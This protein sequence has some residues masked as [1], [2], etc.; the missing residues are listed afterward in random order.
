M[1]LFQRR[2]Q[3]NA[4]DCRRIGLTV[5]TGYQSAKCESA[6]YGQ[7]L[8]KNN[9]LQ[10]CAAVEGGLGIIAAS[11]RSIQNDQLHGGLSLRRS[12]EG[13]SLQFG[14]AVERLISDGLHRARNDNLLKRLAQEEHGIGDFVETFRQSDLR[15]HG[16]AAERLVTNGKRIALF[17]CTE[18]DLGYHLVVEECVCGNVR[19]RV[20]N[21]H[22]GASRFSL[23]AEEQRG[24]NVLRCFLPFCVKHLVSVCVKNRLI[25]SLIQDVVNG[26]K[27]GAVACNRNL[28][29][30]RA[31]R[32]HRKL[33]LLVQI[34]RLERLRKRNLGQHGAGCKRAGTDVGHAFRNGQAGKLAAG[35]E[36]VRS[37]VR[38]TCGKLNFLHDGAA[39][40]CV[41]R[42]GQLHG[43]VREPDVHQ[44][45]AALECADADGLDILADGDTG[46][47]GLT[48]EHTVADF[49]NRFGQRIIAGTVGRI[50][51]NLGYRLIK[52]HAVDCGVVLVFLVNLH[53]FDLLT[54]H[55]GDLK[56]GNIRTQFHIRHVEVCRCGGR[57]RNTAERVGCKIN[58]SL[59]VLACGNTRRVDDNAC[60]FGSV[61]KR[62]GFH[63]NQTLRKRHGGQT[64]AA[65]ESALADGKCVALF[66]QVDFFQTGAGLERFL[67]N[68]G[69]KAGN[70]HLAQLV[71]AL[72]R[73]R[74]NGCNA[75]RHSELAGHS[76]R[77]EDDGVTCRI[78]KHL[79]A[80]LALCGVISAC[81]GN[82]NGGQCGAAVNGIDAKR[83][84]P[85]G[86]GDRFQLGAGINRL[87]LDGQRN[88]RNVFGRNK[89]RDLRQV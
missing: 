85:C 73:I 82:V 89:E 36:C 32:E 66:C 23:R 63:L 74:G 44:L 51:D 87:V 84:Q 57:D 27:I 48:L 46:Q 54:E 72:E 59:A 25:G 71:A 64:E 37:D 50:V 16:T 3:R 40:E 88:F 8:G 12:G 39:V 15:K 61:A 20:G 62:V 56:F 9:M 5:H 28:F 55:A 65:V 53:A 79:T 35:C 58:G 69:H 24:N 26:S 31:G 7:T 76:L 2:R 49:G 43:A 41:I 10:A 33:A 77:A 81:S 78:A 21:R 86:K 80:C 42:D 75:V 6:D 4:L 11:G 19:H 22:R 17:Q 52:E 1:N 68:L 34:H 60:Q 29:E 67:L 45:V 38:K 47:T 14:A 83:G 13:Q 30:L 70:R 18:P